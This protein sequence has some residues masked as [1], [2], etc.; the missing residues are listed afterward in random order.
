MEIIKKEKET[1][2]TQKNTS[3]NLY[4]MNLNK[5][6]EISMMINNIILSSYEKETAD[7]NI[8]RKYKKASLEGKIDSEYLSSIKSVLETGSSK[9]RTLS[10]KMIEKLDV[11]TTKSILL[12][13]IKSKCKPVQKLS[14]CKEGELILLENVKLSIL[15]KKN[16]RQMLLLKRDA[17]KGIQIDGVE[18]NNIISS[19]IKDYS[20]ILSGIVKPSNNENFVIKIPFE[21]DNE[22]ENN[23]NIDDI[24]L[25][26]V[27]IIGIYKNKNNI[28]DI[29]NNTLNYFS[30]GQDLL[31]QTTS[32]FTKSQNTNDYGTQ[33]NFS[34]IGEVHYI[35]II[36]IIQEIK[37]NSPISDKVT[38]WNRILNFLGVN[39]NEK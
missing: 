36:G 18:I 14:D 22:F 1:S 4:Y 19:I 9:E 17:L 8:K 15:D 23:Y 10:S 29:A 28:S 11:K 24:V 34:S 12:K 31:N 33:E 32:K 5:V 7:I 26:T 30:N 25:G 13:Q 39:K 27:S 20:Y 21:L 6:Y 35:D 38:F 16:L 3:F 2:S 37:F